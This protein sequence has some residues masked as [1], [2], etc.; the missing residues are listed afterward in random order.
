MSTTY[1]PFP[2]PKDR[3]PDVAMFLY[4]ANETMPPEPEASEASAPTSM[5]I[6]Q[7]EDLLTRIYV[8]SEPPFRALLLLLA[9]RENP[10]APMFYADILATHPE[11]EAPRSVAGGLGAFGRRTAHRYGGYWPFARGWDHEEW[12]HY[13]TMEA[14][15]ATFL[16]ELH[17]DRGMPLT[18]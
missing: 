10:E 18:R 16:R 9:R 8:E 4:G 5:S 11:W 2:V 3:I 7:R 1:V 12:S 6:E 13:L 17:E 14:D 15:V